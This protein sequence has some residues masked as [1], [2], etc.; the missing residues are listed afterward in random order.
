MKNDSTLA[1]SIAAETAERRTRKKRQRAENENFES[2]INAVREGCTP[3]VTGHYGTLDVPDPHEDGKVRTKIVNLRDDPIGLMH[4]RGQLGSQAECTARLKAARAWQRLYELA[5]IGGACGIDPTRDVVDGGRFET[6][7]T[8]GRLRA[9]ATLER[10]RR[11]LGQIGEYIV[12]QVLGHKNSLHTVLGMLGR[13]G[14]TEQKA[15]GCRFREC[16][17]TIAT[18]LGIAIE[19]QSARRK[20]DYFDES[21]SYAWNPELHRATRLAKR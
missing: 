15:L 12:T 14:Q 9:Q 11:K 3:Q 21:A 1:A 2:A 4:K 10:L 5:E 16:L 8:D 7:D 18:E 17:D 6:P 20:R 19:A 13:S